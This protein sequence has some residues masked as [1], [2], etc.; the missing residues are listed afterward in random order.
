M[1][2][3]GHAMHGQLW[4]RGRLLVP[5]EVPEIFGYSERFVSST[6]GVLVRFIVKPRVDTTPAQCCRPALPH[7]YQFPLTAQA[8]TFRAYRKCEN[9]SSA[10]SAVSFE[11]HTLASL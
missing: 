5:S 4:N 3:R 7:D 2:L 6:Q 9:L 8:L 11:I 10:I 1:A